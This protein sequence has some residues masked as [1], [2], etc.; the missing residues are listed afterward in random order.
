MGIL[1]H[2][3]TATLLLSSLAK[4]D[5]DQSMLGR[6]AHYDVVTYTEKGPLNHEIRSLVLSYGITDFTAEGD[7]VIET[8]RFCFSRFKSNRPGR[9][10]VNDA[11]TQAII[12]KPTRVGVEYRGGDVWIT[13]PETPTPLGIRMPADEALPQDPKDPRIFDADFDGNPGVTVGVSFGPFKGE[14]YLIRRERYSYQLKWYPDTQPQKLLG[15]V[16]DHSEQLVIGATPKFLAVP[17]NPTQHPDKGLSPVY[18]VR[19]GDQFSCEDLVKERDE[20]FP[21]EPHNVFTQP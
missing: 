10:Y 11:F 4:G 18:L 3:V 7:S 9:S 16:I 8:D 20:L 19:V 2:T 12:P 1:K 17:S 5:V 15:Q 13:R 21:N 14:I 6:F